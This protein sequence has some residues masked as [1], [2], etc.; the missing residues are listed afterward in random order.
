VNFSCSPEHIEKNEGRGGLRQLFGA[1]NVVKVPAIAVLIKE[2][3]NKQE[4][5]YLMLN[6]EAALYQREGSGRISIALTKG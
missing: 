1:V 2:L 6:I 5:L 4:H 3:M